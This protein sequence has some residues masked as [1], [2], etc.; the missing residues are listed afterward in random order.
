MVDSETLAIYMALTDAHKADFIDYLLAL[1]G[2]G[3]SPEP[4][5]SA[6]H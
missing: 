6:H 3:D 1:S 2:S 5:L 4:F